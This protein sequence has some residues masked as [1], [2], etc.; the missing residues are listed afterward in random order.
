M[1]G[2]SDPRIALSRFRIPPSSDCAGGELQDFACALYDSRSE[3][4]R[5]PGGSGVRDV[6]AMDGSMFLVEMI[7]VKPRY[8]GMDLGI[9][10]LH[11]YLAHPQVARRIGLVVMCPWAVDK[12]GI[13]RFVEN[14]GMAERRN[15]GL[16]ESEKVDVSRRNTVKL[17]RQYSRMGFR[18]VA[19]SPDWADKWWMSME[20]YKTMTPSSVKG[21]WL[22]K[23]DASQLDI[24]MPAKKHVDSDKD[25]ELKRLLE[26]LKPN[27]SDPYA[28]QLGEMQ[29]QLG[30]LQ[31]IRD[32]QR[33]VSE[34]ARSGSD[35]IIPS[36][37]QNINAL[38]S[39]W[40]DDSG[41][42]SKLTSEKKSEIRRL[43]DVGADL[44]G[45][46]ALHVAA[47]YYKESDLFD[48]LIDEYGMS[49][50][51]FDSIGRRPLHVAAC[52]TNADAVRILVSKGA[53]K[54]GRNKE[55]QTAL[56]EVDQMQRSMD[57]FAR[58]MMGGIGSNDAGV[59]TI[60][61]LLRG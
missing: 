38:L 11:E 37:A 17:R 47:S 49:V 9:N 61:N 31:Q 36:A 46:N 26:S 43:V 18:A 32:I 23:E 10:F 20:K 58:S 54:H 39:R 25:K 19:D 42:R 33:S 45:I 44:N 40:S 29:R 8:R 22:S 35:T 53:D 50:E 24:P 13:L 51:Q 2:S 1:P 6:L 4:C 59:V 57:D 30:L 16:G 56:Q 5:A 15:E 55:G 27:E 21:A 12:T 48:L 41:G 34:V 14:E 60:R 28:A 7:E 3:M 52:C